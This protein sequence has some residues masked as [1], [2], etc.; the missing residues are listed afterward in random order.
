M[1]SPALTADHL[2]APRLICDPER[3]FDKAAFERGFQAALAEKKPPSEL[4]SATVALLREAQTSG[5][6]AIA[7]AFQASPFEAR[8]MTRSYTYLTDEIVKAALR[9]ATDHLHPKPNPTA[10]AAMPQTKMEIPA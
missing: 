4:R 7:E 10:S 6:A 3:I 9:V 8:R 5:R 1:S 2:P